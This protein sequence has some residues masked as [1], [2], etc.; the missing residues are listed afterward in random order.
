VP[1]EPKIN[2]NINKDDS[3]LN[4][5]L[6]CW[7]KFGSR[8]NKLIIYNSFIK[9]EF[10]TV[11]SEYSKEKN[12]FTEVVPADESNIVNDKVLAMISENL[13]LSY[14]VLDRNNENSFIHEITFF[15]KDYESEIKNVN[16]ILEKL[17]DCVI[18]FQEE[19]SQ[20]KLNTI[21][22]GASGLE[23]EPLQLKGLDSEIDM[24]YNELTLKSVNKLIKTIKKS[25]K[26][27]SIFF[28]PRGSGKT[29]I[30]TNISD[31]L[32]RIII[33]IP[34][35]LIEST[36]NNPEFKKFL[37][38]H[39]KPVIVLDDCEVIFNDVYYKSNVVVNNLLQMI[40]GFL[41]DSIDLNVI[42]IFNTD[43]ES[44]IDQSLLE[45][46]NL[47]DVVEFERLDE[48][49]SNDLSI[50]LGSKKKYKNKTK[51]IDIIKKRNCAGDK[52]VGF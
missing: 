1:K 38:K 34:N 51:L 22:I 49:E 39:P 41:S 18:D 16:D 13:Y 6:H 8:P 11:I 35:N 37:M 10:I 14:L 44:D 43:D 48:E 25:D 4:D 52:K 30:L 2:I 3:E 33:F 32:D 17:D 42:A 50:H 31:K 5:F 36:I 46:N 27:L 40:D 12:V 19:S 29:S 28:G 47:L 20:T 21:T 45:C 24:Y 15:F 9:D 26:G 7:G 23:I